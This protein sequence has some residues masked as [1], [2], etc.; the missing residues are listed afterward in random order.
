LVF[1][2]RFATAPITTITTVNGNC[3]VINLFCKGALNS[4]PPSVFLKSSFDVESMTEAHLLRAGF[5]L[6]DSTSLTCAFEVSFILAFSS[7]RLRTTCV[8]DLHGITV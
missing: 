7:F 6:P 2:L 3:D 8:G 4:A 5:I 1:F